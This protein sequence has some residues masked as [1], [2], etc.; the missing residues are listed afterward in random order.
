MP[1][2]PH[3][4]PP[5]LCFPSTTT[6]SRGNKSLFLFNATHHHAVPTRSDL[7]PLSGPL[8]HFKKMQ[9]RA[10]LCPSF[11]FE[12]RTQRKTRALTL[13]LRKSTRRCAH[14]PTVH[15]GPGGRTG[16]NLFARQVNLVLEP[17]TRET[18]RHPEAQHLLPGAS[19]QRGRG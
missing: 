2:Q 6:A 15:Y 11:A 9:E 16:K 7:P 4:S 17:E 8:P 14:S 13:F 5:H 19:K 10:M 1:L 18:G 3:S 12:R